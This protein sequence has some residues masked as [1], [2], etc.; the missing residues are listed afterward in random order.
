[1]KAAIAVMLLVPLALV[2][3][4]TAPVLAQSAETHPITCEIDLNE[5]TGADSQRV[6]PFQNESFL[7]PVAPDLGDLAEKKC[8]FSSPNQTIQIR[9][10]RVVEGWSNPPNFTTKTF[11]NP[12]IISGVPECDTPVQ[13]AA[14]NQTLK[15]SPHPS[16]PAA[17]VLDLFCVRNR[18]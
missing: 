12:C 18:R 4:A 10:V 5:L 1:M 13:F 3:G 11:R 7:T 6:Q 17:A 9:C 14:D 8:T 15:I 2:F 16:I